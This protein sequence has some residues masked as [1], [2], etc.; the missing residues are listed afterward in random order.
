MP[1]PP[2]PPAEPPEAGPVPLRRRLGLNAQTGAILGGLFLVSLGEELWSPYLPRYLDALGASLLVI[3]LWSAGKNLLEGFL[4]WGGGALSHRL[5]ERGT[6]ALVGLLPVVGYVVFLLTDSVG[7]AIAASFLVSSWEAFSV[8][9]TFAVVGRSLTTQHRTAAFAVQSIQKRLPR[10]VGPWIGGLVLAALGVATGVR[11]LLVFALACAVLATIVQWRFVR[12]G[13]PAA[14]MPISKRAVWR[15]MPPSLRRLWWSDVLV[16]WGD[17][18]ARDFIVLYCLKTI[19][20]STVLFG[21]FVAL[22]MTTAL[23][24]YFPIAAIVD[25]GHQ[26]PFIGLTFLLFALTPAFFALAGGPAGLALAFVVYGLREIGEPARKSLITN[27]F[28][29]EY[30]ARGVGL[31]WGWRAFA[32]FPAPIAG[33]LLWQAFGPRALLWSACGVGLA[34]AA[35]FAAFSPP[36]RR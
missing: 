28:P 18:L 15:A 8:P 2:P 29:E 1:T 11:T 12:G 6:L 27:S 31:Y 19:G 13:P 35:L 21:S 26:R 14:P 24:T 23:L 17:W 5:G 9:A 3:G 10:I 36:P 22:Q 32:I 34:G 20:I 30:R 16:R 7:A 25:R 33:A 4:F